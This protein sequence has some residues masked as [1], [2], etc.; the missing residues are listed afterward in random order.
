MPSQPLILLPTPRQIEWL[1]ASPCLLAGHGEILLAGPEPHDLWPLG[2]L[3]KNILRTHAG[4]DWPVIAGPAAPAGAA[5]QGV[6]RIALILL[7]GSTAHP[8]E[9]SLAIGPSSIEARAASPAGL[10]YAIQTLR[11][12]I[13]QRG[14]ELPAL[15]CRDWPDFPN[16]GVMLDISRDKVP[17]MQTLYALVEQLAGWKINQLQLYTEHTFAYRGH[18]EP[19]AEASPVTGEEILALD[20]FC[21]ERFIELVPN[22]NTFGHMNR[23][24]IHAPYHP[25]AECP[26]GCDTVWGHFDDPF[27]LC[28]ADPGSLELVRSLLDELLPHFSSRQVNVGCDETVDLGQGRSRELVQKLG[29]GRVYLDFVQQIYQEVSRRGRCMQYWGDIV[30]QH[31]EL[32]GELPQDAIALEWGYEA[33][34]PFDAHGAAFA[35]A[36][37]PFYVCPGTSSWNSLAGRTDN[38]LGNL[39]SAAINGLKHGAV[40]YLNTDW[41]DNGHWQPLP[42]SYLGFAAGAA[43]SWAYPANADL[44]IAR[45]LDVHVF[46]DAQGVM[47]KLAYDLGNVYQQPGILPHNSSALFRFLQSPPQEMLMY[48]PRQP[49]PDEM[50]ARF[51]GTAGHID[52]ILAP[53]P[54]AEMQRPDAALLQSEFA[55][56]AAASKHA[57]RRLGWAVKT[58]QGAPAGDWQNR[59]A[60]EAD[61]LI[62]EYRRLWLARNRPGGLKD[63]LARWERMRQDYLT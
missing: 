42:V 46:H 4:R 8:Q 21:R 7:P 54:Q 61:E 16:R 12:V 34:H 2:R 18:L 35:A 19:W 25:L 15:R 9:Y 48:L 57:C 31:P 27:S 47:G 50:A 13:E 22:Q 37:V 40:G 53:L 3:L 24:L 55:W 45:A 36:G 26:D 20:A 17:T 51:A 11:Q 29:A 14:A 28:P 5:A 43:F 56:V 41:G 62:A 59:L 44:D 58:A 6:D 33:D 60:Q 52:A 1:S 38:A 39:R 32:A 10:F 23:W 49:G 30:M 63:S